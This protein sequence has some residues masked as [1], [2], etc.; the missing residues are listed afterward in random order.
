VPLGSPV[1]VCFY[2]RDLFER[3]HREPPRT[4]GDYQRLVE[5]FGHPENLTTAAATDPHG[6]KPA[7]NP[8]NK[9]SA[10]W[11]AAIEPLAPL[12]AGKVFLARAASY[13]K[14]R[15][16]FATLFDKETMTPRIDSE[17]FVRALEEL[18]AAAKQESAAELNFTPDH[19]REAFLKGDCAMALGWPTAAGS[20]AAADTVVSNGSV[21]E[22]TFEIGF[23]ELPGSPDVFNPRDNKWQP[24]EPDDNP[25]VPLL[26]VAG[27][28]GSVTKGSKSADFAFQLLAWLSGDEW[29]S[30]VSPAS[31]A[32]TLFRRVHLSQPVRWVDRGISAAAA[33]EYADV[34]AQSLGRSQWLLPPRI[35]GH[36]AYMAALD[37]AV[38]AAVENKKSPAAALATAVDRWR[39]ITN[40]LGVD[41]QRAA[42]SRSLGLER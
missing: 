39:E 34:V 15:D 28:L 41:S 12:W 38:R 30:Q 27:R 10:T 37:D 16:Y 21:V 5:F 14:H 7:A 4:W 33:R 31:P 40:R 24:R 23:V 32:T 3:L 26:G 42:Y 9:P 1:L 11:S 19:A 13:A 2:R 6:D 22:R 29:S 35:P 36:E 20:H 25:H 8:L 17:P 18:V